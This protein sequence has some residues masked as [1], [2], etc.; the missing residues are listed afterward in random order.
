MDNLMV[1]VLES[2]GEFN[3]AEVVVEGKIYRAISAERKSSCKGCELNKKV[4]CA[5]YCRPSQR[6]DEKDIVWKKK[7]SQPK[8]NTQ[9]EQIKELSAVSILSCS[10]TPCLEGYK[11]FINH[12]RLDSPISWTP[13]NE[14]WIKENISGG[15]DWLVDNGFI[16]AVKK[17][18]SYSDDK[19]YVYSRDGIL[20]V[21]SKVK[22]GLFIWPCLGRVGREGWS[23]VQFN[24]IKEAIDWVNN[25]YTVMELN[26]ISELADWIKEK[27]E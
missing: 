27:I 25:N 17:P 13:E 5:F 4:S 11:K 21:L 19:I 23:A 14:L 22:E 26:S 16:K 15:I 24:T 10:N 2:D 8:Y 3:P 6:V 12:F 9:Y 18:F 7:A 20:S 1:S